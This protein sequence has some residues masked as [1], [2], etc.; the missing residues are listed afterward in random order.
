LD[1]SYD[2]I[3][4]SVVAVYYFSNMIYYFHC[5]CIRRMIIY[6]IFELYSFIFLICEIASR[7]PSGGGVGLGVPT[8]GTGGGEG[9]GA[10]ED[11][12]S[13]RAMGG[14]GS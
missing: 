14:G 2:R 5:R 4:W 13:D 6:F 10:T 1:V 11:L 3:Y 12:S 9:G 7:V 8:M